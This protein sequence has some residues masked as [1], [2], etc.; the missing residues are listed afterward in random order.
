MR[1]MCTAGWPTACARTRTPFCGQFSKPSRWP[2][3]PRAK[4]GQ[5]PG[6]R[7]L[8]DNSRGARMEALGVQ[9]LGVVTEEC[10][11]QCCS[12]CDN[13]SKKSWAAPMATSSAAATKTTPIGTSSSSIFARIVLRIRTLLLYPWLDR[14]K[15]CERTRACS[16]IDT[17]AQTRT[18]PTEHKVSISARCRPGAL[19]LCLLNR[20]HVYEAGLLLSVSFLRLWAGSQR[21]L[22]LPAGY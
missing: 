14:T 22:L 16:S 5:A 4:E 19:G 17:L 3:S 7:A 9:A 18:K 2:T 1:N 21:C 12:K 11:M 13:L 10:T 15:P 20:L 6:N 8:R